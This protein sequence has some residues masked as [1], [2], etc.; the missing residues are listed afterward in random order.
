MSIADSFLQGLQAP[1]QVPQAGL[2]MDM[3]PY[4]TALPDLKQHEQRVKEQAR[5][6]KYIDD[7]AA[8]IKKENLDAQGE[9]SFLEGGEKMAFVSSNPWIRRKW[10]EKVARKVPTPSF[11]AGYPANLAPEGG[12]EYNEGFV[13]SKPQ[14]TTPSDDFEQ[15]T[16]DS[17]DNYFLNEPASRVLRVKRDPLAKARNPVQNQSQQSVPTRSQGLNIPMT[18]ELV[19]LANQLTRSSSKASPVQNQSQQSDTPRINY[20]NPVQTDYQKEVDYDFDDTP[21][22]NYINPVQTGYQKE[23]DYDFD[24]NPMINYINPVQTGYYKKDDDFEQGTQDSYDNYFLNEHTTSAPS[25]QNQSPQSDNPMINYINPVQTGYYKKDDDFEQGT[26]D[27]YDNYFLSD[28]F[29]SAPPVQ[30]QSPPART[31]ATQN[32]MPP[33]DFLDNK[34]KELLNKM[35][36]PVEG[37]TY[38]RRAVTR[39]PDSDIMTAKDPIIPGSRQDYDNL[40][41]EDIAATPNQIAILEKAKAD[42]ER[43]RR[44]ID[45]RNRFMEGR[46]NDADIAEYR[47]LLVAEKTRNE[48]LTV[49][50]IQ[51]LTDRVRSNREQYQRRVQNTLDSA[52]NTGAYKT[53]GNYFSIL[54]G[55]TEVTNSPQDLE[56][57]K[58]RAERLKGQSGVV[59]ARDTGAQFFGQRG[60][61]VAP[62]PQQ[63]P[64]LTSDKE[65]QRRDLANRKL[66][67]L[68]PRDSSG[69]RRV[70]NDTQRLKNQISSYKPQ[71]QE[72]SYSDYFSGLGNRLANLGTR[73][74][75]P[76][77]TGAQQLASY[78]LDQNMLGLADYVDDD[79]ERLLNASL[80][81]STGDDVYKNRIG[82]SRQR[83]ID[84]A[85]PRAYSDLA[86]SRLGN[87]GTP[88][89]GSDLE[90]KRTF[91]K[92]K[93]FRDAQ[94]REQEA[95]DT[96]LQD[97]DFFTDQLVS[98]QLRPFMD[99]YREDQQGYFDD[100]KDSITQAVKNYYGFE[101]GSNPPLEDDYSLKGLK[102]PF[103]AARREISD[104]YANPREYLRE[105]ALGLD[106]N[107]PL[108][109]YAQELTAPETAEERAAEM[110]DMEADE[111]ESSLLPLS[112]NDSQMMPG[113]ED[114]TAANEV[115]QELT[116]T[117]E[118][119]QVA[120]Q[121]LRNINPKLLRIQQ[122]LNS[123]DPNDPKYY[124][125]VN[126]ILSRI[127]RSDLEALDRQN[128]LIQRAIGQQT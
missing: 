34:K 127:S 94:L 59:G 76:V 98:A 66:D 67:L 78:A 3:T 24:D 9:L 61:E 122:Y 5:M 21:R 104:L 58:S 52:T 23:V 26:Q 96:K 12:S 40:L 73:L 60:A 97:E 50:T 114:Y 15:G 44:E 10:L 85:R 116:S 112:M 51:Q 57:I 28:D 93:E 100:A 103:R 120:R 7:M 55:T 124:D 70:S 54:P 41:N 39:Y 35:Y 37:K 90:R 95:Y 77:T 63:F 1:L 79:Q 48:G 32:I 84:A 99:T 36:P 125:N 113:G 14:S 46:V 62:N 123:L 83:A 49:P 111:V 19:G 86:L 45:L 88:L 91:E 102:S 11:G 105:V 33:L 30:N 4:V 27:S 69:N 53:V 87:V 31:I 106:K 81:H 38:D 65:R 29:T 92:F 13:D 117:P 18:S 109:P 108:A 25:V 20:I 119:Q 56:E 42:Q 118:G 17:Y 128:D 89:S 6:Q 16:Q 82:Q 64:K 110:L 68:M 71:P 80:Y 2:P 8:K 107:N 47:N 75:R 121:L 115:M 74:V 101:G 126:A 43:Q 22:I 72:Q